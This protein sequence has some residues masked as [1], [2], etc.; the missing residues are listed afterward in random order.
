MKILIIIPYI[1]YPLDSGGNQALF[2]M[3]DRLRKIHDVSLC[4]DICKGRLIQHVD[5]HKQTLVSQLREKWDNVNF[6]IYDGQKEYQ[7]DVPKLG[8]YC[9]TMERLSAL[10]NRKFIKSYNKYLKKSSSFEC[11]SRLNQGFL[12]Y[13]YSISRGGFD[14]IQ[15]EMYEYLYLVYLLPETAKRI[16]VHHEIRFIRNLNAM[17]LY[18]IPDLNNDILY[19]Q[20]KSVEIGALNE[21]DKVVTLSETDKRILSD[22]IKPDKLFPSPAGVCF[23]NTTVEFKPSKEFVFVGSGDHYPNLDGLKWFADEVLPFLRNTNEIYKIHVVGKWSSKLQKEFNRH[24][25]II[26]HGFIEDL[27]SFLNGKISIVPLR[28]GSGMRIKILEAINA[29]SPFIATTKGV[30]GLELKNGTNCV[31]VDSPMQFAGEMRDLLNDVN[32]QEV[33]SIS[34]HRFLELDYN[35]DN[36]VKKRLSIYE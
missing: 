12:N 29:Y 15:I 1:P 31:I 23:S 16:F 3:I 13:I 14:Y 36:L 25:E 35:N 18:E 5:E 11:P 30:E 28:I 17:K 9:I 34:A 4:L 2:F 7:K 8:T 26:F 20:L 10:F 27:T 22:Y 19:R 21:Y 24:S 32:R 6:Y 33:M